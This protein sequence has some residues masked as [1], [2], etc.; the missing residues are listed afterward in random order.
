LRRRSEALLP[1]RRFTWWRD[2]T[3]WNGEGIDAAADR[4]AEA[5][6]ALEAVR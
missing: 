3:H 1:E 6:A 2:D 5:L 4:V